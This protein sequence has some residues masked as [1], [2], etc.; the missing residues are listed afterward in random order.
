METTSL[1][2]KTRLNASAQDVYDSILNA[3]QHGDIIEAQAD[4]APEIG[5]Q[6]SMWDGSI[7]GSVIDLEEGKR[8]VLN[9]RAEGNDSWPEDY[10]STFTVFLEEI[11]G[12]THVE[13]VHEGVP[14]A[15][16]ENVSHGW[17]EYY[18]K[19]LEAYFEV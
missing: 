3:E 17:R 8:I 10:Y 5:Y 9:W 1:S 18:V 6:F 12:M 19:G 4:I 7:V 13:L 16:E 11:D 2:F 14:K 15:D